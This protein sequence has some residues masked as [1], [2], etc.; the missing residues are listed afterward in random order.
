MTQNTPTPAPKAVEKESVE[1]HPKYELLKAMAEAGV[2]F[3]HK[4]SSWSPKMQQYIHGT[5]GTVHVINLE[6]TIEK[7]EA[8][9]AF[10]ADL[11]QKGGVMLFVGTKP[12]A[13]TIVEAE[14]KRCGMPY[15]TNRWLGGTL[16][17]F[18][19]IS[20]RLKY[21]LD[22]EERKS[23]GELAKYTKK[24]QLEFSK[25]L[26]DLESKFGGIKFLGKA[27]DALFIIDITKETTAVSEAAR[28]GVPTVAMVDTNAD[29]TKVTHAIPANDDAITS[30]AFIM[31]RIAD[32]VLKG[33]S[34]VVHES[35]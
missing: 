31:A 12:P 28:T 10:V 7:L 18:S 24:E 2:H 4:T 20:K 6:Q 33:K 21:F 34:A 3:G 29:P 22:L 17:N 5:K 9:E 19:A 13:K 16:T 11:A 25:E 26:K 23:R 35:Q 14:A 27:P 32:A 15:V 30:I 1:S 8:A